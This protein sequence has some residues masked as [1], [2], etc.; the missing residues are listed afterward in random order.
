[1]DTMCEDLRIFMVISRST[2]LRMRN[3]SNTF[4]DKIKPT[5]LCSITFLRKS[6]RLWNNVETYGT[7]REAIDDMVHALCM[8]VTKA[9]DTHI[10]CNSYCFFTAT[11]VTR[12]RLNVTSC[13]YCLSCY[14]PI[15][16]KFGIRD[17]HIELLLMYR[18]RENNAGK[19]VLVLSAYVELHLCVQRAPVW[20]S[21][22]NTLPSIA[23]VFCNFGGSDW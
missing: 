15:W 10:M 19:F 13:V 9:T 1:M 21:E 11:V 4:V 2:L 23:T 12:T 5:F 17:P 3:V 16:V 8:L 7:T 20:N 6:C 14:Y 22:C 18:L